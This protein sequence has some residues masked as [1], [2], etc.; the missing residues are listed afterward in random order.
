[1]YYLITML[2]ETFDETVSARI[3]DAYPE[4]PQEPKITV[5]DENWQRSKSA[6]SWL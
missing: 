5:I 2:L 6:F 3:H 4:D 1:M